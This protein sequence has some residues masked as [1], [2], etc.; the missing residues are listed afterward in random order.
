MAQ[1]YTRLFRQIRVRERLPIWGIRLI[2]GAVL[3][4]FSEI[5]MWQ[6]PPSYSA[7]DWIS[8]TVLYVALAAILIDVTVRFQA[9]EIAGL[10]LVGG[11]YGLLSSTI[12]S[13]SAFTGLPWSLLLRGMGLQ[14]GAGLYGLLFFV[15]VMRGKQIGLREIAAAAA[16]G[17]LW[18]IWIKWYPVQQV[19][20]WGAVTIES[21]TL[22]L[23]GGFAITGALF[24][25]VGP[26][27]RVLREKDMQL[28]WWEWIIAGA[29]LF[30][31]LI[32]GMLDANVIPVLPL[33]VVAVIGGFVIGALLLQRYGYEPSILAQITFAAPNAQT[34]VILS[35]VFLVAGTIGAL[36]T[37]NADSP[38]GAI[39]YFVIIGAGS[40]WLPAASA[41]VGLRAYRREGKP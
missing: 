12:V 28:Q 10:A 21:A 20:G 33:A 25:L 18:G 7:L 14:T 34:Y 2:L 41:L 1:R 38:L 19:V 23:I 8:R 35:I 37:T 31:A 26:R 24:L 11:L 27:F 9:N 5:V 4:T 6:N 39:A 32:V 30:V 3:L 13:H 22:Y 40:L 17:L 16:T 36:L 15:L 29:P